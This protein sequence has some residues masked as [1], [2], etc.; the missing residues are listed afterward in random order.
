MYVLKMSLYIIPSGSLRHGKSKI[1][2]KDIQHI[3][4][5]LKLYG[6]RKK[7]GILRLLHIR[8]H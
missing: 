4:R 5:Y 1:K 8:S 6:S 3:R 7:S 2:G